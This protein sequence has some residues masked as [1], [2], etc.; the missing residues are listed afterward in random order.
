M[1]SSVKPRAAF[2]LIEVMVTMTILGI[3]LAFASPS[4]TRSVE[5]SHADLAG[6]SLRSI[7]SAQRFYW[8]ENRTYAS[9]IDDLI[10]DELVDQELLNSARYEFSILSAD[11]EAFTARARRRSFNEAG[12]AVYNGAW[13]GEFDIDETGEIT[14]DV[15]GPYSA[16]LGGNPQ[17][18]PGF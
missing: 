14:G 16:L 6:A 2:S 8:L 9:D 4:V 13:S 1:V 15:E 12:N 10:T 11:A 18:Q 3:L 7:S 5:Q 17:I